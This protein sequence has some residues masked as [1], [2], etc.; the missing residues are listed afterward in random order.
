MPLQWLMWPSQKLGSVKLKAIKAL[1][2]YIFNIYKLHNCVNVIIIKV[3]S[4]YKCIW[5]F[6]LIVI[7]C[8]TMLCQQSVWT[9]SWAWSRARPLVMQWLSLW[10]LCQCSLGT[11]S[12][13]A[14]QWCSD[15]VTASSVAATS[16]IKLSQCWHVIKCFKSILQY[17]NSNLVFNLLWCNFEIH[18]CKFIS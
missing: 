6:V 5:H 14:S 11:G 13:T 1:F 10:G 18:K 9:R 12:D 15:T 2:Y 8:G 17:T 4:V 3:R 16:E 7:G